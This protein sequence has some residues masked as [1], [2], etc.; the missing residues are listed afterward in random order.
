LHQKTAV[1]AAI[2]F[3]TVLLLTSGISAQDKFH[4]GHGMGHGTSEFPR[5]NYDSLFAA[6]AHLDESE[7][8]REILESCLEAYGGR[9]H[10]SSL[11]S[12]R[13]VWTMETI[14]SSDTIR[15]E[16]SF[17]RD[18]KYRI[19]KDHNQRVEQRI[20]NGS[21]AWF[22][23]L[24][25]TMEISR[26]RFCA[27]LF[28]YLVLA[29]PFAAESDEFAD[30]RWGTM[31]GDSLEYL[32]LDKPDSLLIVLGIDPGDGLIHMIHGVIR[33]GGQNYAFLNLLSDHKTYDGYV[34]AS[35]LINVAMGLKVGDSR[36]D[37]VLVNP[38]SDP[39]AFEPGEI[40]ELRRSY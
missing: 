13:T 32:Y 2:L 33:E 1:S 21:Q 27:E 24:D 15:V 8:G 9:E 4:H 18:R 35:H 25:T 26:G 36:L 22:Q 12:Y 37:S 19:R 40:T 6:A 34:F 28:S 38:E 31:P 3:A 10:L 14:R 30:R 23:S 20:L 7:S 16:R 17:E 11:K 5:F 39:A 29:M